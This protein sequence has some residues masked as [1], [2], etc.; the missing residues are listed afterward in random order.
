MANL[1]KYILGWNFN[2]V[3]MNWTGWGSSDSKLVEIEFKH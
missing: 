3:E 1:T 2:I